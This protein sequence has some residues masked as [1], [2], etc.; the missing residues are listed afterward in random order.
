MPL[1]E[2]LDIAGTAM[3]AEFRDVEPVEYPHPGWRGKIWFPVDE[4]R[5]GAIDGPGDGA[6]G[7]RADRA[8]RRPC[9]ASVFH[10]RRP[11]TAGYHD[12]AAVHGT[13]AAVT[14]RLDVLFAT[15]GS[16]S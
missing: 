3:S 13:N 14:L 8:R 6:L 11:G 16:A 2:A 5:R 1:E 4:P 9:G 15:D 12:G 10:E 7:A